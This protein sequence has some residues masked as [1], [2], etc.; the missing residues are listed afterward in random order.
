MRTSKKELQYK[1]PES[2]LVVVYTHDNEILALRRKHPNYFWQSVAGSLEW[3]ETPEQAVQRELYEETGLSDTELLVDWHTCN[4][5]LIYPIW[6]HRYAPGV[7]SNKEH[8]FSLKIEA[9]C[10]IVLDTREHSEYRW[11]SL[12]EAM[13]QISSHTNRGAINH[14]LSRS[15]TD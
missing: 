4:E 7:I 6:R 12:S 8:L 15:G 9:P 3:D 13:I 11:F 2:V 14:L 1:R 10:R 5:F